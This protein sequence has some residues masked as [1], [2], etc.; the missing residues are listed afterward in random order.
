[1]VLYLV[2]VDCNVSIFVLLGSP[3]KKQNLLILILI[4]SAESQKPSSPISSER[5]IERERKWLTLCYSGIILGNQ[6]T[7]SLGYAEKLSFIEDVGNVGM[8][9]HFDPST[10]LREKVGPLLLHS[11]S[12]YYFSS[13]CLHCC[14]LPFLP[15]FPVID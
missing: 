1:M 2:T 7:M 4:L 13:Y 10:I 14:C 9:E 3:S 15:F 6:S 8:T 5:L 11:P 12:W